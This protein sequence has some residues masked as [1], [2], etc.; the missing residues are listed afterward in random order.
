ML[1]AVGVPLALIALLAVVMLFLLTRSHPETPSAELRAL[2]ATGLVP[3]TEVRVAENGDISADLGFGRRLIVR[4][5]EAFVVEESLTGPA[6]MRV[7]D[8]RAV[9]AGREPPPP[10]EAPEALVPLG[11]TTVG[12][13]AGKAYGLRG[14]DDERKPAIVVSADPA[15]APVAA[16]GRRI[17]EVSRLLDVL[18]HYATP[19]DMRG[20]A[21]ARDISP[22]LAALSRGALLQ[23]HQMKL[24]SLDRAEYTRSAYALPAKPLS[25]KALAAWHRE[26]LRRA[27][28]QS[29]RGRHIVGAVFSAG[30]LWILFDDGSLASV[31][32]GQS[33]PVPHRLPHRVIAICAA[34]HG[35][36]AALGSAEG[37]ADW[38]LWRW[39]DDGWAAERTVARRDDAFAGIACAEGDEVILTTKRLLTLSPLGNR[40]VALGTALQ[41]P[42]RPPPVLATRDAVFIGYDYGEWG[43]GLRRIDRR[44]GSVRVIERRA[45][46]GLCSGPLNTN[47]HPVHGLA[48]VPWQRGCVAAAV[49]NLHMGSAG[50]IVRVCRERVDQLY[51]QIIDRR[52]R[53]PAVRAEAARGEYGSVA[54]LGLTA[55]GD[56]LLAAG[57]DGL[58]RLHRSG[59]A[60]YRPWPRFR[61]VGDLLVSFDYP[62]AAIVTTVDEGDPWSSPPVVAWR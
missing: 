4:R 62:D 23:F 41:Q 30:R 24:E 42:L 29:Q 13:R 55:L 2:Y 39:R 45:G 36:L 19:P 60:S 16:A 35:P 6:V 46:G 22:V 56:D 54:F 1:R 58:Y 49:G 44:T 40:E 9:L 61:Q 51:A 27:E 18:D 38:G 57:Y 32:E 28:R 11:R 25:R 26:K 31:T 8:L 20:S 37:G 33:R 10:R 52:T 12:G 47:C 34:A 48:A 5:G 59:R 3:S 15:L 53:D 50:R 7:E 21:V 43:G 17:E 14:S